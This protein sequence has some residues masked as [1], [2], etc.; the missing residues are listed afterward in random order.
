MK[1]HR[2]P[3]F[4]R[5]HARKYQK[6]AYCDWKQDFEDTPDVE[7]IPDP[8]IIRIIDAEQTMQNH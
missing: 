3:C 7:Y 8:D 4:D 1:R 2:W 5:F 6:L